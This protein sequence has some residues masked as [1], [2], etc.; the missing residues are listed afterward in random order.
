MDHCHRCALKKIHLQFLCLVAPTSL[1]TSAIS[2]SSTTIAPVC[3]SSLGASYMSQYNLIALQDF[4]TTSEVEN[5]TIICGSLLTGQAT[6]GNQLNQNSFNPTAFSLEINGATVSGNNI[7]V[8]AGSVGLGISPANRITKSNPTQYIVDTHIQFNMNQGNGGATVIVDPNLANKCAEI[9]SSIQLLSTSLA[10]LPPNNNNVTFPTSQ[11]GPLNLYVNNVDANGIAVFNLSGN[12][13]LNNGNVQQIELI[14]SNTT[15]QLVVIN[16]YGTSISWTNGNL[17]GDWFTTVNTGRSH[18]IW[19]FYQ[20]TT[21]TFQPNMMGAVLAPYATLSTFSNIDG[22]VAV[23]S[24]TAQNE[25]H[26]PPIVFPNC[27]PTPTQMTISRLNSL[28]FN[29]IL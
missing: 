11:Q 26:N 17:V 14:L 1:S 25:L 7:N 4:S 27:I 24:L 3:V 13:M 29:F 19:N 10:Q 5:T 15:P 9:T 28:C 16:L 20:A 22:A 18:T 12:T 23:K 8:D 6:F 2:P 21:L